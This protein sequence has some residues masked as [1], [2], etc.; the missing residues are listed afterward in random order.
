MALGRKWCLLAEL[1]AGSGGDYGAGPEAA[2]NAMKSP[3]GSEG[4]KLVACKTQ[5]Q[6]QGYLVYHAQ[7]P[8]GHTVQRADPDPA[9]QAPRTDPL[10]PHNSQILALGVGALLVG[11][12]GFLPDLVVTHTP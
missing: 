3:W 5:I 12:G 10:P 7:F 8:H 11:S 4:V 1:G 6:R 2:M 9:A